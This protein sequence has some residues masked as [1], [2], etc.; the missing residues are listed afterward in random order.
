MN[1]DALEAALLGIVLD[2]CD[3][4]LITRRSWLECVGHTFAPDLSDADMLAV[5]ARLWDRF[6]GRPPAHLSP[7]D[8]AA[9]CRRHAE[10]LERYARERER[11]DP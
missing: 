11:T 6:S 3:R 2:R 7:E 4:K 8:Q 1:H 10:E 5:V 9:W